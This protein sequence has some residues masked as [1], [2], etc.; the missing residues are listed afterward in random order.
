MLDGFGLQ[1][2]AMKK[3]IYKMYYDEDFKIERQ[4]RFNIDKIELLADGR[5]KIFA[6]KRTR[7]LIFSKLGSERQNTLKLFYDDLD[8]ASGNRRKISDI[9]KSSEWD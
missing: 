3:T 7:N 2:E 1:G 5:C 8:I 4:H 9:V 6:K